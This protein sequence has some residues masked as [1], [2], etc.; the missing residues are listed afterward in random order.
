MEIYGE[1]MIGGRV[2]ER[3]QMFYTGEKSLFEA[4]FFVPTPQDA[5]NGITVRVVAADRAGGNF[6]IGKAEYPVLPEQFKPSKAR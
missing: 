6:G 4:P 2:I 5:P 3:L 1:V